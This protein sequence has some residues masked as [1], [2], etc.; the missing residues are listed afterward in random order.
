[1]IYEGELVIEPVDS[2]E[3]PTIMVGDDDLFRILD[4][5][6]VKD[7]RRA[8]WT[9]ISPKVRVTVEVLEE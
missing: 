7:G 5:L 6:T 9:R 3:M 4:D 1:M 2:Q 8:W